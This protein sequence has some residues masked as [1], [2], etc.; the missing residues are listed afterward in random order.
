M[1][2]RR[3]G[4]G[5]GLSIDE[6]MRALQAVDPAARVVP[7]RL[8]RRAIRRA[9]G[10]LAARLNVPH[11]HGWILAGAEALAVFGPGPL[12]LADGDEVPPL[13]LLIARPDRHVLAR[14]GRDESLIWAWRR[15]FHARLDVAFA[16]LH[17]Q[18]GLDLARVRERI[19]R[20]G[21]DAFEEAR[22]VLVQ[23]GLLCDPDDDCA[24]YG[25]FAT[26]FLELWHFAPAALPAHF[27]A[28]ADHSQVF[29]VVSADVDPVGIL[30]RSRPSGAVA[31]LVREIDPVEVAPEE[32]NDEEEARGNS[33]GVRFRDLIRR[34]DAADAR[35]NDV[36]AAI[37][38]AS[39]A[40]QAG[41]RRATRT[42]AAARTDLDQL[43]GRLRPVLGLC[44]EDVV[45]WRDALP[46]LL[47]RSTRG[48]WTAE[49]RLLYDLQ[50]A[51]VDHERGVSE[52]DLIGWIGSLGRRPLTRTLPGQ[53]E[54]LVGRHL[55]RASRRLATVRLTAAERDRLAPLL[56]AAVH[57]AEGRLRERFGPPVA[58]ALEETG[59]NPVNLP[60]RVAFEKLVEELLD[61]IVRRDYIAMGD[62]RDALSRSSLK[63]PDLAG[64]IELT[65]GD[66][67]LRADR[68]LAADLDGVYRRGE[69]Y[70]RLLQRFSSV[71]FGTANG[72]LISRNVF[73]PFGG[74]FVLLEGVK[75]LIE[76]LTKLDLRLATPLSVLSVGMILLG[77]IHSAD[78]RRGALAGV[79]GAYRLACWVT[80]EVPAWI[81]RLPPIPWLLS[82]HTF[83]ACWRLGS[84]PL[85]LAATIGLV[86]R[87]GGVPPIPAAGAA[88][89]LFLALIPLWNSRLGQ[90]LEELLGDALMRAWHRLQTDLI[91]GLFRLIMETFA[92]LLEM[93]DRVLYTVDEW[94]RFRAGQGRASLASKAI[95]GPIWAAIAYVVRIA[96]NLLIEPQANPVKHFPVV[97]VSH[98][99]VLPVLLALHNNVL[100]RL[101][102]RNA[103]AITG[104]AQLAI[105]G[106]FGFLVWELKENWRLYE[107][108]RPATL[109]P[110]VVG[111]HGETIA[112]LLRPG[113]HSGTIP[114]LF[115]RLRRADRSALRT[116]RLKASLKH[117]AALDHVEE[118][119]RHFI[120]R[121]VLALLRA[122][123]RPGDPDL[124]VGRI[125][126]AT[127]SIRVEIRPAGQ[128]CEGLWIAFAERSGRLVAEVS[129]PPWLD[130]LTPEHRF[131]LDA[132]LIGL[133]RMAG[134]DSVRDVG[135]DT[136]PQ[137]VTP[138]PWSTWVETWEAGRPEGTAPADG[139]PND[140][141]RRHVGRVVAE[142]T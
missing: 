59:L 57:G 42:L 137:P 91:P 54:V 68:R 93:I 130:A 117:E 70:L 15:L 41:P 81:L 4:C 97:T 45:E 53:R 2:D 125:A 80:R 75:F 72:R 86:L 135:R 115:A 23:E 16:A 49:A 82:R 9:R 63:L 121:D 142:R 37:L 131:P 6:L 83:A 114:K 13:V 92:R 47:A 29:E 107:A 132:A 24:T 46:A 22:A 27:P 122:A 141:P 14:L 100:V 56:R 39:A 58:R 116:G 126:L 96:V 65:R 129:S 60:E 25:E 52:V 18:G 104:A 111:G 90:E 50:A 12:G 120:Q 62:L 133:Y 61:R 51:C 105:P 103:N 3:G 77:L 118:E 43:C 36:R 124:E 140:P 108:N 134:V 8:V 128:S 7:G 64:P 73:L 139:H 102:P 40:R 5:D 98:K 48:G 32:E 76:E 101:F 85:L 106:F 31:P 20:I 136:P 74:A 28:I 99:L 119:V 67:L 110:A 78:L 109:R 66:R 21:P 87:V 19:H 17:A 127:T 138:L 79:R 71:A 112:R 69:I 94:T 11:R 89:A 1:L 33:D 26:V 35:G 88:L 84:R 34:A 123:H 55:R 38:R 10:L 30:W 113:F 44:D 95:L